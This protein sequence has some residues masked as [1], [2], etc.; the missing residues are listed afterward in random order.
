MTVNYGGARNLGPYYVCPGERDKGETLC[1]TTQGARIDSAVQELFLQ[2]MV[3]PELDLSLA[4]EREVG[5]QASALEQHWKL[6]LEQANYEAR[7]AER[8]YKA[9]DPDNRVVART[10]EVDWEQRLREL[11]E[12]ERQYEQAKRE[13]RVELTKQD[14]SRVLALAHDLPRVWRATSTLPA[15]RKAMLRLVIEVI[16]LTPVEVPQR[17]TRVQVQW[18]SGAVTELHVARPSQ[19][20]RLRTSAQAVQRVRVLAAQG[21]R[22]EQIAARLDQE[23][24]RTGRDRTWNTWAVKWVRQHYAI[25]R[26]AKDAP[27]SKRMPARDDAGRYSVAAVAARFGVS[28]HIVR[29]WLTKDVLTVEWEPHR[30]NKRVGWITLD[31]DSERR[32]ASLARLAR[33]RRSKRSSASSARRARPSR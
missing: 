29:R 4:V 11:A 12:L 22:D 15:E 17:I 27:R 8:R 10:L 13:R 20:D 30:N 6:R 24:I 26:V 9:V 16:A 19:K 7:R 18:K 5:A 1:W 3:P 32:A 2:T 21:L 14:R 33:R 28:I 23:G 31:I 25:E